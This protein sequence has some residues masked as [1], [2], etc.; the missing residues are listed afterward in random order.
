MVMNQ[1]RLSAYL[2]NLFYFKSQS[3]RHFANAYGIL[4]CLKR[5]IK[6]LLNQLY[7]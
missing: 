3:F 2:G 5:I 1:N 6:S 7:V 4:K